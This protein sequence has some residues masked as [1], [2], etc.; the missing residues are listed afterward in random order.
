M[1]K[2]SFVY[3]LALLLS[4]AFATITRANEDTFTFQEYVS[5][6]F[7]RGQGSGTACSMVTVSSEA[8]APTQVAPGS[9]FTITIEG[10][11]NCT[12]TGT[13]APVILPAGSVVVYVGTFNEVEFISAQSTAGSFNFTQSSIT[14]Q[15]NNRK[16]I[17]L[18]NQAPLMSGQTFTITVRLR[19]PQRNFNLFTNIGIGANPGSDFMTVTAGSIRLLTVVGNPSVSCGGSSTGCSTATLMSVA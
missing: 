4:V 12:R 18:V 8:T 17:A 10:T 9:E 5:S 14:E 3:S 13:R 2:I 16:F 1:N 7:T 19:A 11:A 6:D 15:A